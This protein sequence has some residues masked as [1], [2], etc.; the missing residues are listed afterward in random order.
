ML[1]EFSNRSVK[2]ILNCISSVS[3][4]LLLNGSV[5]G[6]I[7][8]ER[9]LRQRDPLSPTLFI[10]ITEPLSKMFH[11]GERENF[12]NGVKLR[13]TSPAIFHLFFAD[14]VLIF[15]RVNAREVNNILRCL[16]SYCKWTGQAF[17]LEKSGC[18]FS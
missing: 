9:G 1:F 6:Q 16:K 12:F 10:L 18:W 5:F 2:L 13:R 7:P 14:E 8:T 11:K 3:L 15:C 4:N 17:N